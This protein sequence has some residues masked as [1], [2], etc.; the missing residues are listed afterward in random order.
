[1]GN[2]EGLEN[3]RRLCE[4]AFSRVILVK[5]MLIVW[6]S[7]QRGLVMKRVEGENFRERGGNRREW[8]EVRKRILLVCKGVPRGRGLGEELMENGL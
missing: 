4:G 8:S 3:V 1:M 5:S 6:S 2:L 7:G